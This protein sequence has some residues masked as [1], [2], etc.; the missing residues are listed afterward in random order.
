MDALLRRRAMIAAG[1]YVPPTPPTPYTPVDY[2]E[3]DGT[4]YIN[5]GIVGT[6]ARSATMKILIAESASQ[7]FLGVY[8]GAD[9]RSTLFTMC[10]VS[11]SNKCYF[12][13]YYFY[14]SDAPSVGDSINNGTPFEVQVSLKRYAQ[15]LGVKQ[16]GES[17]FTSYSKSQSSNTNSDYNMYLFAGNNPS[18]GTP[19]RNCVSGTRVYECKI[20]SDESYQTLVF[21]GVPCY[22]NG[23]YGLWDKVSDSFFG[24]AANSGTFIGPS[25]S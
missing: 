16:A 24:N 23:E 11:G 13:Y 4:A 15:S 22:Y 12:G 17:S 20:Y 9:G 18:D 1:G 7:I 25:N 6:G 10:A 5:T 14:S 3:T 2:I 21:N 8:P 19:I